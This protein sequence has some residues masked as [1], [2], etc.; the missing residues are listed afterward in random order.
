MNL[1]HQEIIERLSQKTALKYQVYDNTYQ[2][3]LD[4][5]KA[6]VEMSEE[7]KSSFAPDEMKFLVEYRERNEFE[8]EMLAANDLLVAIMHTDVFEF[9]R[10][11][12]V[13]QMPYTREDPSRS[14]CGIISIYNFLSDSLKY[15][16]VNDLGYLVGRIFINKENH[17]FVEGKRQLSFLYNDFTNHVISPKYVKEILST[18]LSYSIDFDLLVPPFDVIKEVSV[19]EINFIASSQS[20]KTGKRL[21][22]RFEADKA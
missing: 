22:F 6:F 14:Y 7:I 2:T 17:F 3:F 1:N 4:I 9:P 16:R 5:K 19:Q 8:V 18:A 20:L 15:N 11:H 13:Q 10:A 21:G 12:I